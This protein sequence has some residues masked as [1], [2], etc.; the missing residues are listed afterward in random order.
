MNPALASGVT[1]AAPIYHDI[2]FNLLKNKNTTP[3]TRPEG[4]VDVPVEAT[5]G[6]RPS[7]IDAGLPTRV[8]VF[9]KNNIPAEDDM[10]VA[11]KICKPSGK[12]A[13]PSCIAAGQA[14]DQIFLIM[15]DPYSKLFPERMK[16]IC[17][18][19]CPPSE[20][21]NSTYSG[22]SSSIVTT[23]I[24]SPIDKQK[25]T[26]LKADI[27]VSGTASTTSGL[28]VKVTFTITGTGFSDSKS[29]LSGPNYTVTFKNVPSGSY[30]I[31]ASATDSNGNTG[32]SP[33]IT[34][35]VGL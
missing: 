12:L 18:P 6:M 3:F 35:S 17:R 2:M 1:G 8:E 34:V 22:P 23:Q 25:F 16:P 4:I 20:Y 28:I 27:T 13:G 31:K 15:Y 10:H 11:V 9:D 29:S 26:G 30:T 19:T 5:T 32:E 14:E 21:D 33:P 24:T 7:A